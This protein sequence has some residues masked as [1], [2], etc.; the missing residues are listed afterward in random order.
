VKLAI[1]TNGQTSPATHGFA[2]SGATEIVIIVA[3]GTNY[4]QS[5]D[6]SVFFFFLLNQ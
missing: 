3:T 5:K 1:I 2:V 6:D 4:I